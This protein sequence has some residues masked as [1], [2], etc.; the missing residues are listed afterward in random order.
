MTSE[1]LRSKPFDMFFILGISAVALMSGV[2]VIKWPDLFYVVLTI[3]LWFLGYHHVIS[4]Y[5][6]IGFNLQSLKEHKYLVTI[7]PLAVIG[8]VTVL[9]YSFG[10][11]LITTI[12]LYWQW[13]HYTRQSWGVSRFYKSKSKGRV[14]EN[15]NL[16]M[17]L[18]WS[19]PLWGIAHRSFQAPDTFIKLPVSTIPMPEP[20]YLLIKTIAIISIIVW[21][22]SKLVDWYKGEL[23]IPHTLYMASHFVIFYI[24]YIYISDI[25]IGWLVVNIWHNAQYI[26]F[27]WLYNNNRFKNGIDRNEKLISTLSQTKNAGL[28]FVYCLTITT[29]IYYM[30]DSI[31]TSIVALMIIYQSL[32]F[33]H[34]IVDSQIWKVRKKPIREVMGIQS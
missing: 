33:H 29:A 5:T 11:W 4:T 24:S 30:V 1:W 21:V 7:I 31:A 2:I 28:Y 22:L 16:S 9:A 17:V 10:I 8:S 34:Y 20:L 19:I 15:S 3:D 26:I 12:Y 14:K 6:R 18:F 13:Y 32:N 27:V 23:S 25:T